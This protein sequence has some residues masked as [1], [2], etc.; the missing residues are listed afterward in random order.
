MNRFATMN[1]VNAAR[2]QS[3]GMQGTTSHA[4]SP[5]AP[6]A[7]PNPY[8]QP[9]QQGSTV[10]SAS[11]PGPGQAYAGASATA[12]PG[13]GMMGTHPNADLRYEGATD[14]SGVQPGA[15]APQVPQGA[16]PPGFDPNDPNNAALAGYMAR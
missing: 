8:T 12:M 2:A 6:V 10:S 16:P 11:D 1:N 15:R 9:G 3:G 4:R 14:G 13:M 5:V 7:Q